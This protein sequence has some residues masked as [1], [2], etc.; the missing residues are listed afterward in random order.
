VQTSSVTVTEPSAISATASATNVS[1]NA[2]SNGAVILAVSGGTA[3]YNFA[4]S[5]GGNSQSISSLSPGNYSV[6]IT[7]DNG[8]IQTAAATITQPAALSATL[9][10]MNASC[11]ICADGSVDLSV[12]GGT[13]PYEFSWSNGGTTEDLTG[14]LPGNYTVIV[15]DTN[16]CQLSDTITVNFSTGINSSEAQQNISVFPNPSTDGTFFIRTAGHATGTF[17]LSDMSGRE[18]YREQMTS[19]NNG[20]YRINVALP[21]GTYLFRFE[22]DNQLLHTEKL[23]ITN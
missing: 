10:A 17:Y 8:C 1:C 6:T 7:D 19:D 13:S 21:A 18:V 16:G 23:I 9:N 5:N 15:T 2:G 3:P 12:S 11:G 20:S 14:L 4:W 22:N